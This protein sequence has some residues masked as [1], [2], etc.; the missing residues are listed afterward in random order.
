MNDVT[1]TASDII[2][3][4]SQVLSFL[5]A[6]GLVVWKIGRASGELKRA[7]EKID[8]R[9]EQIEHAAREA[10]STSEKNHMAV[11]LT[12]GRHKDL[13]EGHDERLGSL[14]DHERNKWD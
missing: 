9:L 12:L 5:G 3:M 7:S 10:L 2:S 14:E 1:L 11:L 6:A 4:T 13:I 8:A